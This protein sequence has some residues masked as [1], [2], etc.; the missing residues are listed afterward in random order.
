ML[1]VEHVTPCIRGVELRGL[2]N[3]NLNKKIIQFQTS[4]TFS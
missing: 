2:K 4:Q 1:R 3:D